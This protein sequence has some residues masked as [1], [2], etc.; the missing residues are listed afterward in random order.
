MGLMPEWEFEI[1]LRIERA[2]F[3]FRPLSLTW[4]LKSRVDVIVK[5]SVLHRLFPFLPKST[6]VFVFPTK[7]VCVKLYLVDRA[8]PL[9]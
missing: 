1:L 9:D 2:P 4:G 3:A 5:P 6:L 7:L 8:L